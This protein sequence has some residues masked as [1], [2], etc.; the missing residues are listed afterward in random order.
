[1]N[2]ALFS[3]TF[4]GE[5]LKNGD[6]DVNDLAPALLA[7]GDLMQLV[8]ST[9]NSDKAKA[10][11]KIRAT[12]KG[13]FWI[14]FALQQEALSFLDFAFQHKEQVA[15]AK[16]LVDL[17]FKIGAGIT[18]GVA[19]TGGGLF[20]L[21]KWLKGRKPD[22]ID[23]TDNNVSIHIGDNNFITEKTV[24]EL[25]ENE[26]IRRQAKK[27]TD[28]LKKKG[29]E[30]ITSQIEEEQPLVITREDVSSF[31][32]PI[33]PDEIEIEDEE[34]TMTL[35]IISLS[36]KEDN[37]W[38]LTDGL[39]PFSAAIEDVSFLNKIASNEISFA[40]NDYLL[41]RVREIQSQTSNGLKKER[42]IIEV[43]EH[44]PGARQLRLF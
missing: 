43:L 26:A 8:N 6:I 44:R 24:I 41:C 35:Q 21:L 33:V 38:R 3:I 17:I 19:T 12:A 18:T 29:I 20:F 10:S 30:Y 42:I 31:E 34:R 4:K 36:F 5:A 39:E 27:F 15:A 16:E 25:A 7:L 9:V 23:Q 14:Q 40:K 37:K 1:M 13:S 32:I 11:V 22:K 28:I 2:E